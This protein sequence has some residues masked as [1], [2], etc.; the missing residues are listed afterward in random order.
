MIPV[1]DHGS[2]IFSQSFQYRHKIGSI[3]HPSRR[4]SMRKFQ[5]CL[6]VTAALLLAGS[7]DAEEKMDSQAGQTRKRPLTPEQFQAKKERRLLAMEKKISCYKAANNNTEFLKCDPERKP[8]KKKNQDKGKM[9]QPKS[10]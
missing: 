10:N 8:R 6:A 1:D 4:R 5:V 7:A 2:T 3:T 9:E